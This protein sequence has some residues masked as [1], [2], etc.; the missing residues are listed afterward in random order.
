MRVLLIYSN[1]CKDLTLAPPVGLSYIA[2]AVESAGHQVK[3]LDLLVADKPHELLQKTMGEFMPNVVGVSVRNIDN[4]ILQRT[5]NH[6]KELSEFLT[7]IRQSVS[8]DSAEKTQIVLGGPAISILEEMSLQYLDG[9]FAIC[10]EGE[11]SF[12]ALLD[13][14]EN[15]TDYD[16]IPGLCYRRGEI[17]LKNPREILSEFGSSGMEK[18]ID[19]RSYRKK[20]NASWAIQTKRGCPL[21]CEYCSYPSIEGRRFRMRSAKEV[22]DEI[23]M[24]IKKVG[25]QTFEFV[26]STFNA[27][28]SHAIRLCEEIIRRKV[29]ANFTTM[30]VNPLTTSRELFSVMKRAGFNSMM[31]TPEA[32]NDTMLSNYKKDFTIEKVY[33]TAKYIRESGIH[34]TWFFL[35]GGPGETQDTVNETVSFVENELN[36]KKILSIF[37]VGIRIMPGTG[38]ARTAYKEGYLKPDANLAEPTFYISPHVTEEWMIQR[39]NQAVQKQANIV[40]AADEGQSVTEVAMHHGLSL[41]RVAPPYWRF[42]P[43]ILNFPPLY[44]LRKWNLKKNANTHSLQIRS[45]RNPT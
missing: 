39:I 44:S 19:W 15:K 42:L 22:V 8:P 32:A 13:A 38:V 37:I 30:G 14:L 6:L 26:D 25:P 7:L 2:S 28:Q 4:I 5:E 17:I 35:L 1:Q 18:W 34:S 20:G 31:V 9:D 12:P 36:D 33:K 23:E 24:V 43:K 27:P 40:L 16:K 45:S 29:K 10:G 11:K 21:K 41:F 3:F